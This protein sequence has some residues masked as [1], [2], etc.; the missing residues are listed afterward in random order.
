MRAT[1]EPVVCLPDASPARGRHNNGDF[2]DEGAQ[3]K[4]RIEEFKDVKTDAEV[5]EEKEKMK[6][7]LAEHQRR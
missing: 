7:R 4:V 2:L 3:M 1:V 5:R 6:L